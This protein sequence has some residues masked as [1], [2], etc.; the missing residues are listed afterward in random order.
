[1]LLGVVILMIFSFIEIHHNN[2]E[3]FKCSKLTYLTDF[4]LNISEHLPNGFSS[5]CTK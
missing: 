1:M 4:H 3:M 2:K 5:E